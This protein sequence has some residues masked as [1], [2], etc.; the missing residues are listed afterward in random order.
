[1]IM[2]PSQMLDDRPP[3]MTDLVG[4]DKAKRAFGENP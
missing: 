2:T 4:G 1:M 3:R